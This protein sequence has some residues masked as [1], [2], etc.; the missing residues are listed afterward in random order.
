MIWFGRLGT[1]LMLVAA[2]GC[3]I[4]AE[5]TSDSTWMRSL[6]PGDRVLQLQSPLTPEL[7]QIARDYIDSDETLKEDTQLGIDIYDTPFDIRDDMSGAFADID[8]DGE[9]AA[10]LRFNKGNLCGNDACP[11]FILKKIASHWQ[12]ICDSSSSDDYVVILHHK[13][14]GLHLLILGIP[15]APYSDAVT[16]HDGECQ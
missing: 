7:V 1:T 5:S 16:W 3:S 15:G 13:E 4:G 11:V 12:L 14:N 8:D 2:G 10:F 9:P 6:T